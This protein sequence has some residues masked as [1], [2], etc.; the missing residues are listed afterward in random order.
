[1]IRNRRLY[2][3]KFAQVAPIVAAH[4]DTN[5]PMQGFTCEHGSR[6]LTR[7]SPASC[8]MIKHYDNIG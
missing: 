5:C 3:K 2:C 1:M 6:V 7:N 8:Y 4:L